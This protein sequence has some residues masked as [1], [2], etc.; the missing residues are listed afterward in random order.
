MKFPFYDRLQGPAW[1]VIDYFNE[2][3]NFYSREIRSE[4]EYELGLTEA[5]LWVASDP[6]RPLDFVGH[7]FTESHPRP[8]APEAA[9]KRE[10]GEN[11]ADEIKCAC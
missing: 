6:S 10:G 5:L 2:F 1:G 9:K 4:D 3:G 7:K 8:A 11:D